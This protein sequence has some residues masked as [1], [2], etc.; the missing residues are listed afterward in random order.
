MK[1]NFNFNKNRIRVGT[2]MGQREE[3]PL[4]VIY[5]TRGRGASNGVSRHPHY[6]HSFAPCYSNYRESMRYS[7][8]TSPGDGVH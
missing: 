1:M 6:G 5:I 4:V 8:V 3:S 7:V 2:G